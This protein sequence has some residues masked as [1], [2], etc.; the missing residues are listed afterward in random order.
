MNTEI[1]DNKGRLLSFRLRRHPVPVSAFF[2]HTLVLTYAVDP[3]V[4]R[5]LL[6]PGLTVDTWHGFGFIAIALVQTESLRP[7][8]LPAMLGRDFFLS[9]YR[10][11]ARYRRL[12][13]LR[14]LRSETDSRLMVAAG[15]LLTRYNY[16]HTRVRVEEAGEI[17]RV[18]V[19]TELSVEADL[20]S[21]PAPLPV[22]SPF[23]DIRE[24]RRFAGPLPFTFDYEPETHSLVLIEAARERWEPEPVS[25]TVRRNKFIES[26][27]EPVLANAF[28]VGR[29]PYRWKRGVVHALT[30]VAA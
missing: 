24:A 2:R 14:I 28:Y 23:R 29:V 8:F 20:A 26:F 22:S 6:A 1:T 13:G 21:R 3:A 9:G 17:L 18:D 27:P 15:N 4:L 25:V 10:V 11:F 7:S 5:P 12:R 19:G 16:R 30:E